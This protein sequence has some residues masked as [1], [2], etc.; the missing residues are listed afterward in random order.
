[1]KRQ[2]IKE[3]L[4]QLLSTGGDFAEVFLE[5]KQ[6]KS[7]NF[8]DQ[9]LEKVS[10]FHINGYGLRLAKKENTYYASSNDFRKKKIEQIISELRKNVNDKPIYKNISLKRRKDYKKEQISSFTDEEIKT[11]LK[12]LDEKIRKKEDRI[13]QVNLIVE[14]TIQNV[15]IAN[16]TGL[17][18][19]EYRVLSRFSIILYLKDQEK[20]SRISYSKGA[21][22]NLDFLNTIAFEKEIDCL[23]KQGLDKLYAKPCIGKEMPVIIAPGFGAVIFH[24]ACGHAMEA[25]SVAENSSVLAQELNHKIA[26]DKVTIIDDGSLK[27]EWG[28]S[29][30]DDEGKPTQKNILIE[31]GVLKRFLIDELNNR[32]MKQ[33][34]TGS[35]RRESYLYA[36]T[37]RM[38]NTYL[39][40]GNDTFE[41]MIQDIKLGL[42]A[43]KMGGGS[44]A[45]ETGEFNF[46]VDLGYMIRDGKIAECVTS[47]SLIG[48]TKEILQEVEMVGN[49]FS[50]GTGYCGS[51][52]GSVPV[53]V[54]QPTIKIGKILVGG[55]K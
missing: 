16:H 7:F 20:S 27:D 42:Y 4:E 13:S 44:V 49:D 34:T 37:S 18:V 5:E 29:F 6:V 12:Q 14:N 46:G 11:K 53:T 50:L 25:S 52:S 45:T 36:P 39:K 8:I 43:V 3:I 48:N 17:Y 51:I 31:N 15:T 24:E 22:S 28:S 40:A 38:N 23:I 54:G 2:Q 21:S 33:T 26:T 19:K 41:Q 32:K 47:A 9:M 10:M 55:E 30:I 1:M 35:G